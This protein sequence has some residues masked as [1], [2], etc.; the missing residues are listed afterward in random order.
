MNDHADF[1]YESRPEIPEEFVQMVRKVD[2]IFTEYHDKPFFE[3][4]QEFV[5]LRN[6]Y[7]DVFAN[8]PFLHLQSLRVIEGRLLSLAIVKKQPIAKCLEYL[9]ERLDLEY[10]RGDIY[11]KAAQLVVLADYA[12]E[13][14]ESD[15]AR[16]LLEKEREQLKET[17]TF[18]QSWMETVTQRI[19]TLTD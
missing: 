5:G 9:R 11:V 2:R 8:Q 12:V 7:Q 13:C 18:C 19:E 3:G 14:G 4:E 1:Q 15:L 17:A 16:M 10:G 6:E